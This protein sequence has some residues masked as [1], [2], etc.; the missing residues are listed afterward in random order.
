MNHCTP[1]DY[2]AVEIKTDERLF[3]LGDVPLGGG[4][5]DLGTVDLDVGGVERRCGRGWFGLSNPRTRAL[6]KDKMGRLKGRE[7]RG[8]IELE[9][10]RKGTVWVCV[11]DRSLED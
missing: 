7:E 1:L 9:V 4:G 3:S 10:R 11:N 5:K 8:F 6:C 2:P